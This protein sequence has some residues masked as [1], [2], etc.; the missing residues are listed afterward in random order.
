MAI[1][2]INPLSPNIICVCVND[3]VDGNA[4]GKFYHCYSKQPVHFTDICNLVLKLEDLFDEINFPEASTK[5]R[6]FLKNKTQTVGEELEKH[7][8]PKEVTDQKG[9]KATFVV[10]V[11]YRQNSTWQGNVIWADKNITKNFRSALE[12]LKL[13]DQALN[14]PEEKQK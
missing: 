3:V 8:T 14:E 11:Q 2:I 13:M 9:S 12:L 5:I 4:N 7:M 6:N 1:E 10:H